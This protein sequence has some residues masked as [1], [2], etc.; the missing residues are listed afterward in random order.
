M[1]NRAQPED[2]SAEQFDFTLHLA[3]ADEKSLLCTDFCASLRSF[4]TLPEGAIR[5][6]SFKCTTFLLTHW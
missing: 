5:W 6:L 1:Y 3:T 2:R 4:L